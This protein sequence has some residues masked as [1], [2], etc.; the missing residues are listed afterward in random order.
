MARLMQK[1]ER[2]AAVSAVAFVLDY[3]LLMF[4]TFRMGM[5]PV[6]AGVVSFLVVNVFT[7][8]ASMRFVFRQRDDIPRLQEVLMFVLLL[9]AGVGINSLVMWVVPELMGETRL[10]VTVAKALASMAVSAWNFFSRRQWLDADS[11]G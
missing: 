3:A 7:Y 2:F 5:K 4:L 6:A 11:R 9:G 8:Y 1:V 10:W